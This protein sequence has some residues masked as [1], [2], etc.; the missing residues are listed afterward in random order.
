MFSHLDKALKLRVEYK[1]TLGNEDLQYLCCFV[2]IITLMISLK[3]DV[4]AKH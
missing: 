1:N 4:A 3:A 2:L